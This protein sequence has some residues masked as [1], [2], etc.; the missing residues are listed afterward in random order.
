MKKL[1]TLIALILCV[2]IGGVYAAW[3]YTGTS[4][5]SVD[6]TLSHGMTASVTEGDL[7]VFEIVG[8]TVDVSIDQTA[9]GNYT[10]NLVIT[11][12]VTVTFTPNAGAPED[13]INNA[14][15][16]HAVIYTKNA[17]T[18]KY[19]G[20][21]IYVAST[22]TSEIELEWNKGTDG[23]FTATISAAEIDSLLDLGE[24]FVLDTQAKYDA[25][26]ALEENITI[27]LAIHGNHSN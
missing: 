13:V 9:A 18:N 16:A 6:R 21:E 10:A 19:N 5:T 27:S 1:S 3:T 20:S 11:G 7:G 26:H 17:D 2:T 4:M 15:P 12:E 23:V 25:F 24:D 8:N 22:T 14:V